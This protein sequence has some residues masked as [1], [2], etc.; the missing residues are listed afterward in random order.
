[1]GFFSQKL[2]IHGP[3]APPSGETFGVTNTSLRKT[4]YVP[5]GQAPKILLEIMQTAIGAGET[6]EPIQRA[7]RHGASLFEEGRASSLR[8]VLSKLPPE[9]LQALQGFMGKVL[10][11]FQSLSLERNSQ[12]FFES[13]FRLAQSRISFRN[14]IFSAVIFDILGKNDEIHG[15]PIP[16]VLRHRALEEWKALKAESSFGMNLER[17]LDH[18]VEGCLHPVFLVGYGVGNIVSSGARWAILRKL[19]GSSWGKIL[20]STGSSLLA[21]SGAFLAEVPS[22]YAASHATETLLNPNRSFLDFHD[23][24]LEMKSLAY[25]MFSLRLGRALFRGAFNLGHGIPPLSGQVGRGGLSSGIS[26]PLSAGLGMFAG[27]NGYY[28]LG[29]FLGLHEKMQGEQVFFH[30]LM[31]LVQFQ[32]GGTWAERI[33]GPK[34]GQV[35]QRMEHK[36]LTTPQTSLLAGFFDPPVAI[37]PEGIPLRFKA[38]ISESGEWLNWMTVGK[39]SSGR[40]IPEESHGDGSHSSWDVLKDLVAMRDGLKKKGEEVPRLYQV[41]DMAIQEGKVSPEQREELRWAA[42]TREIYEKSKDLQKINPKDISDPYQMVAALKKI[43]PKIEKGRG[44]GQIALT[45]L[46]QALTFGGKIPFE[47]MRALVHSTAAY[48]LYENSKILREKVGKSDFKDRY[49]LIRR[50]RSLRS[51]IAREQQ[52]RYAI[53]RLVEAVSWHPAFPRKKIIEF[54]FAAGAGDFVEDLP[55]EDLG[56][57]PLRLKKLKRDAAYLRLLR[58]KPRLPQSEASREENSLGYILEGLKVLGLDNFKDVELNSATLAYAY[59]LE[60]ALRRWDDWGPHFATLAKIPKRGK[61]K[62]WNRIAYARKHM[63]KENGG[64]YHDNRLHELGRWG[65]FLFRHHRRIGLKTPAPL[66]LAPNRSDL[67]VRIAERFPKVVKEWDFS[68]PEEV[69]RGLLQLRPQ[70]MEEIMG[71]GPEAGGAGSPDWSLDLLVKSLRFL[72]KGSRWHSLEI[73]A[74]AVD[75]ALKHWNHWAGHF[76]KLSHL[77]FRSTKSEESSRL[78]YAQE[79]LKYPDGSPVRGNTLINVVRWGSWLYENRNQLPLPLKNPNSSVPPPPTL[80]GD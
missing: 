37:T 68:K 26:Q 4:S 15:W 69:L 43:R 45:T 57:S 17:Q 27:L 11:E 56:I 76:Q 67:Q 73:Y 48:E 1:M 5:P 79:H 8:E 31:S 64:T 63:F 70:L 12:S 58:I 22:I 60:Q 24:G 18:F 30:S 2:S 80:P 14:G 72:R 44:A 78:E 19:I 77:P 55:L 35:L 9:E 40:R 61:V 23:A 66:P 65:V 75:L 49:V 71:K 38:K 50:L 3:K 52:H 39:E 42:Y 13:L 54:M 6:P 20:G 32:V 47:K 21:S 46:I 62:G 33:L 74:R 29:H 7:T 16:V 28:G 34:F 59:S 53:S 25:L 36:N 41:L 10:P 51:E